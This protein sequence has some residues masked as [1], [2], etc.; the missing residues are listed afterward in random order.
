MSCLDVSQMYPIKV[1]NVVKCYAIYVFKFLKNNTRKAQ[2]V[3]IYSAGVYSPPCKMSYR[4]LHVRIMSHGRIC[5]SK[6]NRT[7]LLIFNWQGH[8]K[9]SSHKCFPYHWWMHGTLSH[10]FINID[11]VF[12]GVSQKNQSQAAI[13]Y[14]KLVF[15]PNNTL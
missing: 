1:H 5:Y 15:S 10:M 2:P 9:M 12:E 11:H 7:K 3:C 14:P 6:Y 8:P 13:T 4:I